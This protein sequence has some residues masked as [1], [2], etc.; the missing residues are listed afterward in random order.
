[1]AG[2]RV[3]C[4]GCGEI[5][6]VPLNAGAEADIPLDLSDMVGE[7][8]AP[9]GHPI[10]GGQPGGRV[11][12]NAL[13]ADA[14]LNT[15]EEGDNGLELRTFEGR[16]NEPLDYP[17]FILVDQYVPVVILIL[18]A[19]W[20]LLTVLGQ[21]G[22]GPN[23]VP[24]ARL[25][26][27]WVIYTAVVW[28]LTTMG[29]TAGGRHAKVQVPPVHRW[30]VFS[31]FAFPTALGYILWTIS[32]GLS[33][34]IMGAIV[35]LAIALVLHYVL[36]RLR[37]K[38]AVQALPIVAGWYAGAVAAGVLAMLGLNFVLQSMMSNSASAAQFAF[39][40]LGH[41]LPWEPTLLPPEKV[42]P[43]HPTK[44]GP[45]PTIPATQ[46]AT[47]R[48]ATGGQ[49]GTTIFHDP[50]EN[51]ITPPTT[52]GPS[53]QV[54]L[55]P[56]VEKGTTLFPGN[57]DSTTPTAENTTNPVVPELNVPSNL[58]PLLADIHPVKEL[59]EFQGAVFPAVPSHFVMTIRHDV[60]MQDQL[61]VWSLDPLE[62]KGTVSVH[63]DVQQEPGYILSPDGKT[64][65]WLATFPSFSLQVS[66]V[67]ENPVAR[68][69]N[70]T[71]PGNR[72]TATTLG[73]SNEKQL[74]LLRQGGD[75]FGLEGVDIGTSQSN[76]QMELAGYVGVERNAA[77][78]P[79][80]RYLAF[81]DR[82]N[83]RGNR[84][85][86]IT[87]LNLPSGKQYRHLALEDLDGE[88]AIDITGMAF[89]PD[90]TKIAIALSN[91]QQ[92]F[93]VAWPLGAINAKPLCQHVFP[94][95]FAGDTELQ[96]DAMFNLGWLNS[97]NTWLIN[98]TGLYDV[99]S[100]HLLGELEQNRV[101]AQTILNSTTLELVTST[102]TPRSTVTSPVIGR[103]RFM[104]RRKAGQFQMMTATLKPFEKKTEASTQN[105]E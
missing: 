97:D 2:K 44:H 103:P 104:P 46:E 70:L 62:K 40:P 18:T 28:P 31:T 78:S 38:E 88:L 85:Y 43:P 83:R 55:L 30:R 98:G 79:D 10:S 23:W 25:V 45:P 101:V 81:L 92:G 84:Q 52:H 59:G 6:T 17:G 26:M 74:W 29:S 100:G 102:E 39:S 51:G 49:S 48:L 94:N 47:T 3:R 90:S 95:G 57:P 36:Y 58:P 22:D 50:S 7:E 86:G 82:I 93:V 99:A 19:I 15:Q 68:V 61:E 56:P 89:S 24:W 9:A 42:A 67:S 34:F 64:I 96:R 54:A 76:L 73:F 27:F 66:T 8:G 75:R 21:N 65:T 60:D 72:V 63:R 77:F 14:M 71:K 20:L 16:P 105:A 13:V 37:E 35:G 41:Y 4:R 87:V 5:F 69:V 91:G 12:L 33:N 80:G 32:G 53:T 11:P 1:M